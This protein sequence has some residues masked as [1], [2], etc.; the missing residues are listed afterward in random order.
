MKSE[1]R[2]LENMAVLGGGTLVA[3]FANFAFVIMI[4]RAFG[5]ELLGHYSLSMA[6]SALAVV[7]VSFGTVP[8]LTR[9]IGRDSAQGGAVLRA[10]FPT[11][12]ALS[13]VALTFL[14]AIG[15]IS[16]WSSA[17]VGILTAIATYQILVRL[18]Q[19]MLTESQ[20]RQRMR[21]VALVRAGI[22]LLLLILAAPLLWLQDDRLLTMSAMPISAFVF[23]LIAGRAAVRLGGPIKLHWNWKSLVEALQRARP[24]FLIQMLSSGYQR[25]GIII[26]GV[27]AT[28][29]VVGEFAAGERIIA[30]MGVLVNVLAVSALPALS[31]LAVTDTARL[32]QFASRLVR[33]AWLIGLPAATGLFL[34]SDDIKN[35]FLEVARADALDRIYVALDFFDASINRVGAY[36]I[37]TRATRKAL[38]F[39]LLDPSAQLQQLEAEGKGAQKL[40]L[41]EDMKTLPFSAV[42]DMLCLRSDVPAGASWIGEMEDYETD[43][44]RKRI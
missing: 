27:L 34:F 42:W 41:M 44:Q 30:A 38:L 19:I 18:G 17:E 21:I 37:G 12:L 25:F 11:Q 24:F 8:M 14:V 29:A 35:I 36:V 2:M 20:G 6:I 1:R 33:L 10:L 15:Q 40:A 5:P 23:F 13:A 32:M 43:V 16:G 31:H 9:D 26:L 28:R 22:P 3:Q 7:F 4:A 39:G